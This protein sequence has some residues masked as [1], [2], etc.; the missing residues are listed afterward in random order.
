MRAS[1]VRIIIT[2]EYEV[3]QSCDLSLQ[4]MVKDHLDQPVSNVPVRL[5]E[6]QL[7][8]SGVINTDMQCTESANSDL[9]GVAIFI[10]NVLSDSTK[11]VLK[12]S[13]AAGSAGLSDVHRLLLM[14]CC[15]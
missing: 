10:C 4:V 3:I 6:R 8:R 14:C 7:F 9:D 13:G 1:T 5:V 15:C 12:V 11:A 2:I